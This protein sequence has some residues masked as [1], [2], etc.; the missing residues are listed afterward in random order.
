[1]VHSN[2]MV[3]KSLPINEQCVRVLHDIMNFVVSL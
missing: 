1:M 2:K 3:Y